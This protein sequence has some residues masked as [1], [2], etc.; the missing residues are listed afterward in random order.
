M[1]LFRKKYF[2]ACVYSIFLLIITIYILLDTF[3]VERKY[4]E[5]DSHSTN[6]L[7]DIDKG[8]V[9]LTDTSYRDDNI[10]INI[11]EYREYDTTIYVADIVL[12]DPAYLKTAL[13]KNIYGKNITEKTS[14]IASNN[15][16][17]LAINGDYYGVKENGYVLKN[18]IIYRAKSANNQ[19]DLVIYKDGTFEVF[20]ESDTD[21]SVLLTKGAYNVFAFGPCLLLNNEIQVKSNDEV[22]KAKA[23]NPRTAIGVVNELHYVFIVSDGRTDE[24]TG[25]SL[26]QLAIFLKKLNVSLA[27]NLDGGGSSTIYFNGK[28]INNPTSSGHTIKERSVSDIVYIGY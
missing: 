1:K 27:Y 10:Q 19:E 15:N 16:A 5:L 13:A 8:E 28:V 4:S 17:L 7:K 6:K 9:T 26:Y 20:K 21:I 2:F 23:S 3:V 14:V 18:G 11:K 25:L 12:N 24:S 22:G